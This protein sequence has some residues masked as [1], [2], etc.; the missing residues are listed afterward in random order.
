VET[1]A[2]RSKYN[3]SRSAAG[4]EVPVALRNVDGGR[5]VRFLAK[6]DTGASFCIFQ[7][8]YAEQLGID[9]E[10]GE[11]QV[12]GTATGH[13]DV[14]GHQLTLSC[15]DWEF[16]TTVYFAAPRGYG[17]NVSLAGYNG[18]GWGLWITMRRYS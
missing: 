16:V 9:V 13:F 17:R 2:F 7:R 15:L 4:I 10:R 11:L 8:D 6:V 12:V 5:S 18:F 3:Y 1:L 14:Y